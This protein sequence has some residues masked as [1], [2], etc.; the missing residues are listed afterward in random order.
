V[1]TVWRQGRSGARLER[2]NTAGRLSAEKGDDRPPIQSGPEVHPDLAGVVHADIRTWH[3]LLAEA[4]ILDR[5]W[6]NCAQ[7]STALKIKLARLLRADSS[8]KRIASGG[9]ARQRTGPKHSVIPAALPASSAHPAPLS[10][11]ISIRESDNLSLKVV[12]T[13]L[14]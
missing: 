11:A 10:L 7:Y 9:R 12:N 1:R 13:G 14:P 6:P 3:F 4:S 5:L 8:P 2:I